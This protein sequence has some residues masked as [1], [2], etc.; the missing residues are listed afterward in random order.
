MSK[1]SNSPDSFSLL[2][3]C[4]RSPVSRIV[5][6]FQL[7]SVRQV[8]RVY[9]LSVMAFVADHVVVG[10]DKSVSG[11]VHQLVCIDLLPSNTDASW[12]NHGSLETTLFA[13][14]CLV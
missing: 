14:L 12:P 5:Y 4:L 9:T 7:R 10:W 3:V 13:S 11:P 6:V 1:L 2:E 8:L